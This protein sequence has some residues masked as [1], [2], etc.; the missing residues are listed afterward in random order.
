MLYYI[1]GSDRMIYKTVIWLVPE[2]NSYVG[3]HEERISFVNLNAEELS[4][5]YIITRSYKYQDV[6]RRI[7]DENMNHNDN[8]VRFYFYKDEYLAV[9]VL[10]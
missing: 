9:R 5:L 7:F 6:L 1:K 4:N 2:N 10:D 8:D 3:F